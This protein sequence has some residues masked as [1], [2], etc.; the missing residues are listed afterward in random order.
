M[1]IDEQIDALEGMILLG[2]EKQSAME[3]AD[4]IAL[5]VD[6]N[7][8]PDIA[9][10]LLIRRFE[11]IPDAPNALAQLATAEAWAASEGQSELAL[12]LQLLWCRHYYSPYWNRCKKHE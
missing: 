5:E 3:L 4:R 6:A 10:R 2:A 1:T 12:H 11:A 8:R 7:A 9:L